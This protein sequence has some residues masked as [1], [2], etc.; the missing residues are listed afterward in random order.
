MTV[1]H[2][3]VDEL[4][5]VDVSA[6][7]RGAA[8]HLLQQLLTSAVRLEYSTIAPYLTAMWSIADQ[9]HPA[10]VSVRRVVQQEM[11]HTSLAANLLVAVGGS[12]PFASPTFQ[13]AYPGHLPGGVL[14][15]LVV[16]LRHRRAVRPERRTACIDSTRRGSSP[17][18]SPDASRST[19][20]M[21]T[22]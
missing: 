5:D 7:D 19:S 1:A 10:A 2:P 6:L 22:G 3:T 20:T 12:P 16:D 9:S 15:D 8:I 17:A 4:V 14:P 11:L 13:P 18:R 21:P